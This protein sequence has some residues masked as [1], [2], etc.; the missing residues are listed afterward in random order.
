MGQ[1]YLARDTRLNRQVAL[2]VLHPEDEQT[3]GSPASDDRRSEG[4]ARLLR[5][6]QSAAA[7]EHANV[8]T[9][10]EVGE[11]DED[12]EKVPFIAME[13]VKGR[14]LRAYVGDVTIPLKTRIR[15]LV[16]VARALGAAHKAG[17]VHRD[18]KPENVMLRDDGVIKVLDFGLAKRAAR[19]SISTTSS[20]E[21]QVLPSITA[22]GIAIGTPHYMAPEQMRNEALDGRADQFAWGVMAYELLSGT[23]PWGRD[24][25]ALEL[26]SKVL[27]D[28]PRPLADVAPDVPPNVVA[29]VGRAMAKKRTDRFE[30]TD[31]LVAAMESVLSKPQPLALAATEALA[32]AS[33]STPEGSPTPARARRRGL[34]L[35]AAAVLVAS[36]IVGGRALTRSTAKPAAVIDAA[37]PGECTKLADCAAKLGGK[38]G[39][40][41][42]SHRC[43]ELASEDCKV[44]ADAR[45]LK[46]DDTVWI[47]TMFPLTVDPDNHGDWNDRAV[48]LA[49]RDFAEGT[50]T[51]TA[52]RPRPL[53]VVAC[54]DSQAPARA[55]RHLV[56][57]IGTPAVIGFRS[58]KEVIE[59]SET[60][61]AR[62]GVLAMSALNTSP[63]LATLPHPNDQPR[64]VWR[65]TFNLARMALPI[66]AFIPGVLEPKLRATGVRQP[67][68]VAL[69][70]ADAS[71]ALAFSEAFFQAL[72][73]NGKPALDNGPLYKEFVTER[74]GGSPDLTRS[75][76]DFAP[77][78]VTYLGVDIL[79]VLESIEA[80]WRGPRQTRPFY[81]TADA[82][83]A[84]EL[85]FVGSNDDRRRRIF[86]LA[87]ASNTQANARF[88]MRFNQMFGTHVSRTVSPNTAYDAFYVL[89]YAVYAH[90]EGPITGLALAR[91]LPRLLPPGR[92]VE[93]GPTHIFEGYGEL[94]DGKTIDLV[95]STS[96]L[97]FDLTTGDAP[98]DD[99]ILCL[100]GGARP[101]SIE[102]G[103]VYVAATKTLNGRFSCP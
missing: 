12:G 93:V 10:Y 31:E 70:R 26:V 59:L 33:G 30:S 61:F 88:V 51:L 60:L 64:L 28:H 54:D 8:V 43:V 1:V 57:D 49:R 2:K 62:N 92:R 25:D 14:N 24:I 9:I 21:A 47:G 75:I 91:S 18:I 11:V 44:L 17:L 102:S 82:I 4:A 77:N 35:L 58:G 20:T 38:Q 41:S 90:G 81:V 7:L 85:K 46:S 67:L 48:D 98:I 74:A 53:G 13:L 29:A 5:E 65:T 84:D 73:F 72:S 83:S 95:G 55:A 86:G 68:R 22:K 66:A 96:E 27:S 19:S 79:E 89:A 3:R 76:V 71:G 32:P 63:L 40:C 52:A 100:S 50:E 15:W 80:G 16:D 42:P 37:P 87:T 23:P 69:V 45:A 78:V 97:D 56:E 103:L 39:I 34:L 101:E 99:V 6:A 36:A 94:R